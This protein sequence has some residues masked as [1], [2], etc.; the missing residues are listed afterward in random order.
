[1]MGGAVPTLE[2]HLLD[3][4]GMH[5]RRDELLDVYR[6][7]YADKIDSPFFTEERYWDRLVAYAERDGFALVTGDLDDEGLVGYALGYTLPEGSRWW[8][9]LL[10]GVS[11]ELV[12]EDGRRTFALTYIMVRQQ[13]RRHGFARALHDALMSTRPEERATL[14]VQPA[15]VAAVSAY[16]S[17]GWYKVGDLKPFD[18]APTYDAMLF[19]LTQLLAG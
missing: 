18:D 13:W 9:G 12:A 16:R 11:P 15:N 19:D 10:T 1:M 4:A 5:A 6:D 17:W 2:T 14:L 7:A 8:G 3:A